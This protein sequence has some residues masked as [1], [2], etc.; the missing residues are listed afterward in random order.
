MTSLDTTMPASSTT[1]SSSLS[2]DHISSSEDTT[3]ET[4]PSIISLSSSTSE[5]V[6]DAEMTEDK[7]KLMRLGLIHQQC[8]NGSVT[9]VAD[10]SDCSSTGS[11]LVYVGSVRSVSDPCAKGNGNSQAAVENVMGHAGCLSDEKK[12][13]EVCE[14]P[15]NKMTRSGDTLRDQRQECLFIETI[16]DHQADMKLML[17]PCKWEPYLTVL[18]LIFALH[19]AA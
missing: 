18:H 12:E 15:E 17:P 9:N 16:C 4:S 1:S 3:P 10:S 11:D 13:G 2:L 5:S 6:H 8:Y 7:P 14:Q 19:Q